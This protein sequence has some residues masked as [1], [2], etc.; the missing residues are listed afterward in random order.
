MAIGSGLGS[1]FGFSREST[2]GT[3]V[4]PTKFPRVTAASIQRVA[5]RPQG[6]GITTGA[7]LPYAAHNVETTQAAT[8]TFSHV[9]TNKNMGLLLESLFGGTSTSA[10]E[11]GTAYKQTHLLDVS[12]KKP[13]TLQQGIPYRGGTV[14]CKSL[15]GGKVVSLELSCEVGG[16][17]TASWTVDGQKYDESQTLAAASYVASKPFTG[18]QLTVKNGA[19][20]SETALTGITAMSV[21]IS[22]GLDVD[23][24]TFNGTGLKSEPVPNALVDISGSL[25][26]DWTTA[27]AAALHDALV[28]NSAQSLVF[29]WTGALIT[30]AIYERLVLTLPGCM[31]SG[32]TQSV[33]GPDTLSNQYSFKSLFDGT[34]LPGCEVGTTDTAL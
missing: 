32:D 10:I 19:Y 21:T 31:F 22:T 2:Y 23:D 18:K 6:E 16:L 25:T 28:A 7:G 29:S 30:G 20:G 14:A 33:S 4:A 17:L 27:T 9:V 8:A 26:G 12:S 15:T 24:Y 1:Q 5:E 3:Y 13:V 11:S 34:N